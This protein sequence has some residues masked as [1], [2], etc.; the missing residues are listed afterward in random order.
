MHYS[1]IAYLLSF[2]SDCPNLC[3]L[4]QVFDESDGSMI[5]DDDSLSA[6]WS[7]ANSNGQHLQLAILENGQQFGNA[8]TINIIES[9]C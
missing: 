7:F 1:L 8:P 4:L 9:K 5:E 2:T 3:V 6:L